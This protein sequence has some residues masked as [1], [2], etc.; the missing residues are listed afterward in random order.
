MSSIWADLPFEKYVEERLKT[1]LSGEG[2]NLWAQY[3]NTRKEIVNEVLPWIASK[4]PELTDHG[5]KHIVDVMENAAHLLG[6]PTEHGRND[7]PPASVD[8]SPHELFVLLTGLLVHDIGNIFG[9]DRHNQK[10]SDVLKSLDAVWASWGINER[11]LVTDVGRAH[12]GKN[13]NGGKDTLEPLATAVRYFQKKR[14]RAGEIAAII[15]FADELAEGP[16]RT[17]KFLLNNGII[18]ANSNIYHHYASITQVAID[19]QGFRVALTYYID[20]D[21]KAYP[22]DPN[23]LKTFLAQ[24]LK[25][26]YARAAKMNYERQFARHYAPSLSPFREVS[27][28]LNM[29]RDGGPIDLLLKPIVLTDITSLHNSQLSL[30]DIHKEYAV[31]TVLERL[32]IAGASS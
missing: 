5:V 30:E 19:R 24:L 9:R 10:I 29:I 21:N 12:S 1:A 18:S 15:R 3:V 23:D 4:E 11:N 31:D 14:I 20:I 2:S 25:M 7:P 28:S 17:S 8:L 26:T 16:Q 22:K 6:L 27:I 32:N 13:A